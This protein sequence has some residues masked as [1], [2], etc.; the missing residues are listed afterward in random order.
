MDRGKPESI[1]DK[2]NR[3]FETVTKIPQQLADAVEEGL[4][5]EPN[6]NYLP[7]VREGLLDFDR[8]EDD[9]QQIHRHLTVRG[10]KVLGS[11][12]ILDD[13]QNL[14]EIR[15]YSERKGKTFVTKVDAQVKRITNVP[16]DVLQ[17]LQEQ[18]RI[19]LNLKV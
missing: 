14:M 15:T 16:P 12:L 3:L 1:E 7:C 17:A 2:F 8:I 4:K 11:H 6:S 10:D 19:E 5:E 18:G 13:R 9:V